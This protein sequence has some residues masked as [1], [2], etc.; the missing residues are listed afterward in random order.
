MPRMTFII[1][2]VILSSDSSGRRIWG[3]GG[4]STAYRPLRGGREADVVIPWSG[5]TF[6]KA[7]VS[8]VLLGSTVPRLSYGVNRHVPT[9]LAVVAWIVF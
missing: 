5:R 6:L 8:L 2:F 7:D 1:R 3:R 4:T 9:L